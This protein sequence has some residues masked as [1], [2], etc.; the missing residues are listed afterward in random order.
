MT[1]GNNNGAS[2]QIRRERTAPAIVRYLGQAALYALFI[3]AIGY[4]STSPAH[5]QLAK[6]QAV[7]KLAI[8]HGGQV[9]QP[10]RQRTQEELAKIA[11]NMREPMVCE[12]ERSSI[13]VEIEVDG[14]L[15]FRALL[16]PAGMARDGMSSVYRRLTI[17]S[18]T[19]TVR[20]RLKDHVDLPDSNFTKES[21]LTLV[22]G[23]VLVIDFH[24]R[25][26]GFDF[27]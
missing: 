22:P 17:P 16:P 19:H 24:A 3:A 7:L 25:S 23:E 13:E 18:G 4:L 11:P 12:R 21:E 20:A 2:I 5:T 27:R 14:A 26:G 6:D 10:C 9:K 8:T 15:V 1:N